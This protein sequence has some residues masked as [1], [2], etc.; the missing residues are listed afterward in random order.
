MIE[1]GVV[2]RENFCNAA[3]LNIINENKLVFS[4]FFLFISFFCNMYMC[5]CKNR[6]ANVNTHTCLQGGIRGNCDCDAHVAF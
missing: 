4:L 1:I 3:I 6:Y 2:G 5:A